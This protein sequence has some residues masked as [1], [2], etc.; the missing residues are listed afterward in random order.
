MTKDELK[1][2]IDE[3]EKRLVSSFAEKRNECG[4]TLSQVAQFLGK[5]RSQLFKIEQNKNSVSLG[6]FNAILLPLGMELAI[7]RKDNA[8]ESTEGNKSYTT[9]QLINMFAAADGY[10]VPVK[11]TRKK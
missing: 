9:E 11:L 7:V 4:M 5:D 10:D 6:L 3:S 8:P 2:Y 1:R